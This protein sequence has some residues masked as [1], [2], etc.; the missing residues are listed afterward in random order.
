MSFCAPSLPRSAPSP[1]EADLS[2]S[3]SV[4]Y[5]R[6]YLWFVFLA[7]LDVLLTY[8]ILSPVFSS[9]LAFYN[10]SEV[11]LVP[12]LVRYQEQGAELNLLADWVIRKHDVPGMVA[13]KFGLAVLILCVCEAVGR[14]RAEV[15]RRLSEWIVGISAVPVIVALVQ[16]GAAAAQ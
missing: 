11:Q 16:M 10:S 2:H 15:G 6:A 12:G 13:Y 7:A 5:P 8:L 9:E 1:M 14:R 4:L 3:P